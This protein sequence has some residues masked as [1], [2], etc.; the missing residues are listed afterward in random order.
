MQG[1]RTTEKSESSPK[2]KINPTDGTK[3]KKER[4]NA[5]RIEYQKCAILA[6]MTAKAKRT[7]KAMMV[8]NHSLTFVCRKKK[9]NNQ[10]GLCF[11]FQ[12][13]Y[14]YTIHY[15]YYYKKCYY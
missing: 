2:I 8:S 9:Q 4:K 13:N 11:I 15:Y 7:K 14:L 5:E 1:T 12:N 10:H 6:A 3:R